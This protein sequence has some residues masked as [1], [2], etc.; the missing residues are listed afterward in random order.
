M[1]N[2]TLFITEAEMRPTTQ[3][4]HG[5]EKTW[6]LARESVYW[7]NV[8]ADTECMVKQCTMGLEYQ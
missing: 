1:I 2:H 7:I 3:Q 6:L 8:N 5:I 4:P